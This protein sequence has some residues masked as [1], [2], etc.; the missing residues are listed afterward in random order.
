MNNKGRIFNCHNY[1][2]IYASRGD[3]RSGG[4]AGQI[5]G[6]GTIEQ[7]SNAGDIVLAE[8][9]LSSYSSEYVGGIVGIIA[10]DSCSVVNSYNIGDITI[11]SD[12][13]TKSHVA[14]TGG[15]TAQNKGTVENCYNIGD[16]VAS[17]TFT[18]EYVYAGGIVA[19]STDKSSILHSYNTGKLTGTYCGGIASVLEDDVTV[20]DC[21][22]NTESEQ[23]TGS[24]LLPAST[25]KGIA[26]GT[27]TVTGLTAIQMK[28]QSSYNGFD[29]ESI[30]SMDTSKNEGYPILLVIA[31]LYQ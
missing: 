22:W 31:R 28:Q 7:S 6:G 9:A 26:G 11:I 25:R 19:E 10:L 15:I 29:F 20:E 21:Y 3:Q 1:G 13:S 8:K 14:M 12:N 23:Y 24:V 18:G 17:A 5:Y 27:G 2:N 30:W 16:M 4:I